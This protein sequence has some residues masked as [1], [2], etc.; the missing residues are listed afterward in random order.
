M[1]TDQQHAWRPKHAGFSAES[2]LQAEEGHMRTMV[3][4]VMLFIAS[5]G[6]CQTPVKETDTLQSLL[7][8]VH[9]L[10]MD[11]EAMTVA[12]QR[13]QIA[14]HELQMQDAAVARAKQRV[15]NT[16]NRCLGAERNRLHTAAEISGWLRTTPSALPGKS[17]N[18]RAARSS[19]PESERES[20]PQ[21]ARS[22]SGSRL[23]D[24][25]C[26]AASVRTVHAHQQTHI[27][28][29]S[30]SDHLRLYREKY[31]DCS[32]LHFQEKLREGHVEVLRRIV[33]CNPSVLRSA[34]VVSLFQ[35][36]LR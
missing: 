26:S 5:D 27:T 13:V 12:S 36:E 18:P 21:C 15:D 20:F 16:Q 35:V 34:P 24:R 3:F 22:L 2:T 28:A 1:E 33:A 32:M 29:D 6:L 31:F 30:N 7:A 11:I 9:Q 23:R 14:L 10:R 17:P 4:S 19:P 25:Y 8:E